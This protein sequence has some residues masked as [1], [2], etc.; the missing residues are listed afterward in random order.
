MW[1]LPAWCK[2]DVKLHVACWFH[3]A[4][5]SLWKSD[6]MRPDICRLETTCNK[7]VN[8]KSWQ[9]NCIKPVDKLQQTCYHQAGASNA[10]AF[11][12]II[13]LSHLMLNLSIFIVF[14]RYTVYTYE[15]MFYVLT[16]GCTLHG[17]SRYSLTRAYP[18]RPTTCFSVIYGTN[19]VVN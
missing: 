1:I 5:L 8:K 6:F 10:N 19:K 12:L 15:Y 3:Q 13:I 17:T 2:V 16:K 14:H 11:S 7:L 18:F 4:V 9:W